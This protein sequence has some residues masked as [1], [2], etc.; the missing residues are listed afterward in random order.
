MKGLFAAV[1]R[2]KREIM[3]TQVSVRGVRSFL[4]HTPVTNISRLQRLR[5]TLAIRALAK[6]KTYNVKCIT[7]S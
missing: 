6:R 1:K 5:F 4:A 7:I 2:C 3:D